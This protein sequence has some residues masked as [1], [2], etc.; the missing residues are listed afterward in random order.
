MTKIPK[1]VW[2]LAPEDDKEMCQLTPYDIAVKRER[3]NIACD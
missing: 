2:P 3:Y 1:V